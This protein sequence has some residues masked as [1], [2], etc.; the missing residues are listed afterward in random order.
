MT[1]NSKKHF[2]EKLAN[3]TAAAEKAQAKKAGV[4]RGKDKA[5]DF[6]RLAQ[7]R[8]FA[9]IEKIRLVGNLSNSNDYTYTSEQVAMI[10]DSI[11]EEVN[12]S[13]ARFKVEAQKQKRGQLKLVA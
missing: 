13:R 8:H 4:E 2:S 7:K 12:A 9:A 3:R 5:A 1:K 11:I 6:V 10:F